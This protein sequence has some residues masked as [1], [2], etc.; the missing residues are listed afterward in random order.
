[1]PLARGHSRGP[2][3][4]NIFMSPAN[5][6]VLSA[7]KNHYSTAN[8]PI[9]ADIGKKNTRNHPISSLKAAADK[10]ISPQSRHEL[11]SYASMR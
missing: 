2:R 8:I 1:M 11:I 4:Y 10:F 3:K 5:Y 7:R 6:I 9:F